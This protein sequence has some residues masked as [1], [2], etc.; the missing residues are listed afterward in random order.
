MNTTNNDFNTNTDSPLTDS[1]VQLSGKDGNAFLILGLVQR[2]I[3]R[4][5]QPQ[6]AEA[7]LQEATAGDYE[8]PLQTCMRYV[9]VK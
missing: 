2:T 9:R 3:K 1:E 8:H 4:S 6:V 5:N 7:F